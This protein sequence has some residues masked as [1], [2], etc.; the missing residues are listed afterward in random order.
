MLFLFHVCSGK[1][2]P[3]PEFWHSVDP[4]QDDRDDEEEEVL[5][6]VDRDLARQEE[7]VGHREDDG[8][9]GAVQEEEVNSEKVGPA[10]TKM[11]RFTIK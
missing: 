6:P 7:G 5:H 10:K 11:N 3:V 9:E 1:L 2:D 8:H 4:E